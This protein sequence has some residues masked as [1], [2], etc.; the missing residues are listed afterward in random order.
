MKCF[1]HDT[2]K[3]PVGK[4]ILEAELTLP[5]GAESI[6][7]FSHAS[8]RSRFSRRYQKIAQ[9][10]QQHGFGTLLL[11]L[12]TKEEDIAYY[13]TRSNIELLTGRLTGVTEWLEG[14]APAAHLA[15]GYFAAGTGAAAALKAAYYLPHVQAVVCHGGRPDMAEDVL[16]LITT[17]V[18]LIAGDLDQDILAHNV[19]AFEKLL[20][21][22]KLLRITGA[23]QLFL[24]NNAMPQVITGA[25]SWFNHCLKMQHHQP[26]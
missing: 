19:F 1:F 23:G 5:R 11:D 21:R 24:E 9:E 10:L 8:S 13:Y 14:F 12:L 2:V 6:V 20:C 3:I 7:I 4:V 26:L 22:K 16:P 25:V 15:I 17:P 18:M